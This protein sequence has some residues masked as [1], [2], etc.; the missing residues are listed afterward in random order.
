MRAPRDRIFM[1][2]TANIDFQVAPPEVDYR[3]PDVVEPRWWEGV[4]HLSPLNFSIDLAS[5]ALPE[6]ALIDRMRSLYEQ[7]GIVRVINRPV[8]DLESARLIADEVMRG[9]MGYEAGANSRNYIAPNIFEVGAPLAALLHYHHEMA[10]IH[11]T[12][13]NLG[14]V[15]LENTNPAKGHTF[16]SDNVKATDLIM[17]TRLDH[18]LKNKDKHL[19]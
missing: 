8:H 3:L 10:Y 16:M 17:N 9:Q 13:E 5:E 12:V 6:T 15:C 7:Y 19:N 18:K 2:D 14:F 11:E 1:Q 4:S